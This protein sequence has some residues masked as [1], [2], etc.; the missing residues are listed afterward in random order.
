[1]TP[2]QERRARNAI[3][4]GVSVAGALWLAAGAILW[5]FIA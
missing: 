4:F 1:M 2:E 3:I 5:S